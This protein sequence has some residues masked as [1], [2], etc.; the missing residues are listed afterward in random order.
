MGDED[1]AM[2]VA[3]A[4]KR[5]GKKEDARGRKKFGS[6]KGWGKKELC[7]SPFLCFSAAALPT[8]SMEC[9]GEIGRRGFGEGCGGLTGRA[10]AH[11]V[12]F[13][14][15]PRLLSAQVSTGCPHRTKPVS[16]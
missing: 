15:R 12:F 11:G 13:F 14:L 5:S 7:R 1:L 2:M 3:G 10:V 8:F 6:T 4:T 16:A 9:Q